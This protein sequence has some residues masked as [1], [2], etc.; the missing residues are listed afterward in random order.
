[1]KI[2]LLSFI[3]MANLYAYKD[4]SKTAK[5]ADELGMRKKDYV[6]A[7]AIAGTLTGSMFGLFLWKTR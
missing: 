6:Y 7:M 1:M 5:R 2:F 4:M 3:L